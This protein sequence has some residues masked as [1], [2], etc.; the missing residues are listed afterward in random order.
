MSF[1]KI[2]LL[3][4]IEILSEKDRIILNFLR[5]KKVFNSDDFKDASDYL[6]KYI[7]DSV[8]IG[9]GGYIWI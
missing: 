2:E 4:N 5:E 6:K 9:N 1:Q 3:M 7:I 8:K